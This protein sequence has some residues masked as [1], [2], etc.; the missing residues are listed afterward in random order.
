[1]ATIDIVRKKNK[2]VDN[3][4]HH[5]QNCLEVTVQLPF[6]ASSFL[7]SLHS[8]FLPSFPCLSMIQ[9]SVQWP[10]KVLLV[11]MLM[12]FCSSGGTGTPLSLSHSLS[13][14][15]CRVA[16]LFFPAIIKSSSGFFAATLL[17]LRRNDLLC[18]LLPYD[19]VSV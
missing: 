19:C 17:H 9:L 12:L 11:L 13:T 3:G 5:C 8:F 14:G 10:F 15:S 1:M 18:C 16:V 4:H 6:F 7:L 2:V